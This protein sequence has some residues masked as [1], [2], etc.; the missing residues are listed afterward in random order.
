V[1]AMNLLQQAIEWN[2][3]QFLLWLELGRCQ[4]AVGLLT[5]AQRSFSQA[6]QINPDSQEAARALTLLSHT[7]IFARM[8]AWFGVLL[9]R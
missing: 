9:R 7:G 3:G 8:R 1:L 5:A 6:K 2:A 4:Q